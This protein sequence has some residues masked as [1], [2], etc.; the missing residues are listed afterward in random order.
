MSSFFDQ[1]Q[2][3]TKH[4]HIYFEPK[5]LETIIDDKVLLNPK[6]IIENFNEDNRYQIYQITFNI[7][8]DPIVRILLKNAKTQ[9][10]HFINQIWGDDQHAT[11]TEIVMFVWQH[12]IEKESKVILDHNDTHLSRYNW[13]LLHNTYENIPLIA[14]EKDEKS[15]EPCSVMIEVKYTKLFEEKHQKRIVEEKKLKEEQERFQKEEE[16]KL[17]KQERLRKEKEDKSRKQERLRKKKE[18]KKRKQKE[19][20]L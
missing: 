20:K 1:F 2:I 9:D 10:E 17:H 6:S 7:S 16:D 3:H 8:S 19:N 14:I 13:D 12:P 4:N 5:N 18:N 15:I 11:K